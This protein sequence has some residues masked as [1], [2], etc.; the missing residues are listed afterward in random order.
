MVLTS[1]IV[2][3]PGLFLLFLVVMGFLRF[4]GGW[5]AISITLSALLGLI[6]LGLALMPVGIHLYSAKSEEKPKGEGAEAG[7]SGSAVVASESGESPSSAVAVTDTSLEVVDAGS[8]ELAMT[9]EFVSEDAGSD[10][11]FAVDS[12]SES[13][14][15]SDEVAFE[16]EE[17]E[18][19]PKKR[20]K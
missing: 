8:D 14:L 16:E 18:E 17:P 12:D 20:K 7:E 6:G 15:E 2:A 4:G 3:I 1:L 9:G 13:E 5:S 10:E 11:E 19:E